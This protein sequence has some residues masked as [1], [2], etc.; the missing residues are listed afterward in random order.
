MV[1]KFNTFASPLAT[2]VSQDILFRP[3]YDHPKGFGAPTCES[4]CDTTQRIQR[5]PRSPD[6]VIHYGVIAS[7]NQVMRNGM[8]RDRISRELG[9]VLCFEMEAAGLMNTFPCLVIRG[10]CDYSDSHKNKEWQAYA[11][12]IAAAYTKDLLS[13]IEPARVDHAQTA[14]AAMGE[15][16]NFELA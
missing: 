1:S 8:E 5:S 4:S 16:L 3:N 6:P 15:S 9:G 14:A 2:Q 7:G 13:E 10:I 12:A 11:A